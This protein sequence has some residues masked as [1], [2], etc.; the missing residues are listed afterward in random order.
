LTLKVVSES[1]DVGYLCANLGLPRPLSV[2]DL[3]LYATD[4]HQTKASLNAPAY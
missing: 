1:R 3:G 4:R 2:L